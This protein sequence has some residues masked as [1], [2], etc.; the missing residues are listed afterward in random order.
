MASAFM[1]TVHAQP[2]STEFPIPDDAT[3]LQQISAVLHQL[4]GHNSDLRAK[5][6]TI[7]D[8]VAKPTM[9][10]YDY[11]VRIHY[12]TEFDSVCFLVALVYLRRLC[13]QNG[14][15]FCP[16]HH[17]IHRLMITALNVAAKANDGAPR[18]PALPSPALVTQQPTC[19][20]SSAHSELAHALAQTPS[21]RTSSW[22]GAA[23]SLTPS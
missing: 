13:E 2:C 6:L 12:Y 8:C 5:S 1:Q 21:T 10:V 14:P 18:D 16:T 17:N 3:M 22:P 4:C 11:L 7:F 19:T 23:A 15:A 20:L 9:P